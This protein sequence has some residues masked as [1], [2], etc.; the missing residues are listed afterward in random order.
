[1]IVCKLPSILLD[2]RY[3]SFVALLMVSAYPKP[4]TLKGVYTPSPRVSY[5]VYF[6]IDGTMIVWYK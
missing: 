6:H 4:Y 5:L 3:D 2:N 1:M